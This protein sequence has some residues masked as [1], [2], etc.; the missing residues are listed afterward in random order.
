MKSKPS[1][2]FISRSYP[3]ERGASGR[4]VRDVAKFF[5]KTGHKVTLVVGTAGEGAL[6]TKGPL[7]IHRVPVR[8]GLGALGFRRLLSFS[9][10]YKS[11]EAAAAKHKRHDIVITLSVPPL[12]YRLG[13]KLAKNGQTKHIHWCTE[14]QPDL[15]I[16][17]LRHATT[18]HRRQW[19]VSCLERLRGWATTPLRQAHHVVATGSCM[20][21][22][23][24]RTGVEA[25]NLTVISPWLDADY[26]EDKLKDKPIEGSAVLP[27]GQAL[28]ARRLYSDPAGQKF[29]VLWDAHASQAPALQALVD[30]ARLLQKTQPDI[31]ICC[32]GEGAFF[33]NLAKERARFSLDN[34]RLMPP[35][36]RPMLKALY[37]SGDI[38]V[39]AMGE[40]QAGL[41][42]PAGLELALAVE[43]PVIFLGP[44][45]SDVARVLVRMGG[46]R[47]VKP[48]DVKGFATAISLYRNDADAW[49]AA[50]NGIRAIREA[51]M[52]DAA[53]AQWTKLIERLSV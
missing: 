48:L 37:E 51:R 42:V 9:R 10:E 6:N 46:G 11:F 43:R 15:L 25:K 18:D 16:E 31:E 8:T 50:A 4:L 53:F 27:H 3:P 38:H 1:L 17:A 41:Y 47:V 2:M 13:G 28:K 33:D 5:I 40:D 12:L 36:P 39:V 35:Q 30:T 26:L 44:S 20:A 45:E 24:L 49:F 21:R 22:L 14:L 32:V 23:L 29:R 34:I 19:F 7:T 52:P